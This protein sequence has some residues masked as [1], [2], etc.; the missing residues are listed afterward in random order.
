MSTS[1]LFQVKDCAIT[2]IATGIKARMLSELRDKLAIIHPGCIYFHFWGG[3][4]STQFEY[5]DYHNDFAHWAHKYLHDDYL[6]ERLELINPADFDHLEN[7]RAHLLEI[8][9][10]RLDELEYIP[11]TGHEYQ[12]HFIR[13]EIVVT[14]TKLQMAQPQELVQIIPKLSTSSL[15]YHFIDARRRNE[16]GEDDFTVWLKSYNGKYA[17]LL[18][19]IKA[20]DPY[21]ISLANVHAKLNI[22]TSEYFLKDVK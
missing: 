22:I 21:L 13:S 20:V 9:D 4:L 15:F 3:R 11:G 18:D 2:I 1:S 6:G 5:R 7:L 19:K 16:S 12:F 17:A 8:V 10:D 14:N